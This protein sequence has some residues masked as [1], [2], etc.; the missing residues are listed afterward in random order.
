[1]LPT[2]VANELQDAVHRFLR[3]AFPIATPYFQ[4][5]ARASH[6]PQALIDDLLA[7]PGALFKGP[8][9]D[10]KLPFRLPEAEERFFRHL[11]LPFRP[12]LHQVNAF[13]R[14]SGDAP[15][16]TIIATGTGSGKTE[17]FM[18]PALDDC[19]N[20]REPGIKTIV[21]YPMNALATDQAERFAKEVNKLDT[22]LSVGLFVGGEQKDAQTRMSPEG[23]ITDQQTLREHPPDILLTNYK[24]LDFLLIRPRD[25]ALWQHNKPG[26]LRY[27]VVD[28]LHTF[29]GAQGTDLACLIRRLRDRLGAGPELACVGTSA[30]IGAESEDALLTYAGEVF[31]TGFDTAAVVREDRLS[32]DEYLLGQT[33]A[34]QQARR[35]GIEFFKWPDFDGAE[36]DPSDFER[37]GEYLVHQARLWFGDP[38]A[39]ELAG[40]DAPDGPERVRAAVR[41]GELLHRHQ[42]FHELVR[43]TE[44]L[45]DLSELAEHWR[46]R[47]NLKSADD[48]RRLLT[49]LASLVAAARLWRG[50][51]DNETDDTGRPFL[52]I[53]QQ[54]WLRELRRLV[55][56]VPHD[57][58]APVIRFADDLKDPQKP[59]HLPL[60][61]CRECHMAAWGA[62]KKDGDSHL[63]GDLQSFY[64]AWFKDSPQAMLLAPMAPGQEPGGRAR[65]FCPEC[66]RLQPDSNG[67]K[68]VECDGK[69][70]RR[71]WTPDMLK[72]TRKGGSE[73][74]QCHHDC[75]E[76]GARDSLA[77]IGYRAATL[78][79]VMTGRLFATPYN[80]D[81][82]LIAFSDSVQDAAHRAGFLGA[83]TWRQVVRQTMTGW[84]CDQAAP[85]SL[86]DVAASLPAFWRETIDDDAS[87][88]GL[89]I[90]PNMAWLHD[91]HALTD[92]GKL[93][94][95]SDLPDLIEK[96][97]AWECIAEFGRRGRIGR[98]L[99]R[100]GSAAVGLDA[101]QLKRDA[102]KL[103]ARLREEVEGLRVPDD[104]D[105]VAFVT[106]WLHHLRHIG[107]IYDP[108]LDSYLTHKGK[109]FL[110]NRLWWMPGF[111]R[112]RRPPAAVTLTHVAPNFEALV[113]NSRDTWSVRWLKK[114]LAREQVFVA[115][116]ARQI[117]YLCLQVLT[118]AGWLV[119]KHAGDEPLYLLNPDRLL[120]GG[121][122]LSAECGQC[123]HRVWFSPEVKDLYQGLHCLRSPC[124]G[125]LQPA[126]TARLS[127]DYGVTEPRRLVPSEHTGLLP[128][129]V[130]ESV[131]RSFIHGR[132]TW[133]INLLSATPT[134]EMGI[135]IGEL[136]SVFLCSVPPAQANYL[137]RIGR[138]GR[139]DGNALAVTVAN[140]RNHD[141]FF[142]SDPAE[143]IA[144]AVQT[145]GV[146]LQATA[147]LERQLIAYCF[148][149]WAATGIDE[150][151]IPGQLRKVLDAVKG[152][153]QDRFPYNLIAFVSS[154]HEALLSS[155]FGVFEH[156]DDEAREYLRRFVVDTGEGTLAWRLVNR[157]QQL[158]EEREV[159]LKKVRQLKQERD[160][161][162][163][164]PRDEATGELADLV[165]RERGALLSL[166]HSRNSQP[167][168]NFFT[169]EGL[170]PN[171]AF[172]EEGVTLQSVILRRRTREQVGAGEPSY[173]KVSYSFQ[174]PAQAALSELAPESRFYAV[175]HEM[176]IEQID[177][178]LS[179]SEEW[180]FCDRCQYTE[181][182]DIEDRHSACPRCG[183]AQWAD[184]GQKHTVLKLRQVYSTID[185]R[186]GRIGDDAEQRE[187]RFF[188][189]QMLVD[190]PPDGN[191]GGFRLASEALPFGFEFLRRVTLREVN[192][193]SMGGDSNTF[194][195]AGR[196]LSRRGFRI[197]R[198]CGKVQK[199]RW[200]RG[201]PHHAFTCTLRT[202]PR[203]ETAEDFFESLYLYRELHSEAI[204]ILLPLSEVAYSDEKLHSFVAALNLGLRNY[205]RGNVQHLE[206]TDMHE[207]AGS[208]SGERVYLVIYDRIP[209]GTGYL[210]ELMRTPE[211]MMRVLDAARQTLIH[212]DCNDNEERD[213]CYRCILAY[214]DSRN[215]TTISRKAAVELL[216]DILAL[217]DQ[218]EPVESLGDISTNVLIESKLEQRFVDALGRLSGARMMP[219]VINGK[220]GSMLT[221]PGGDGRPMP[222]QVEHQV[223]VGPDQGVAVQTEI[224][225]LLT[226]ARADDAERYRPIAVYLDG[227]QYHHDIVADDVIK[228]SA[229][230]MSGR[231]WVYSLNWHDI[232]EPGKLIEPQSFDVM[233][234]QG[235]AQ[236]ELI[237]IYDQVAASAEW[238]PSAEYRA[239]QARGSLEWLERQLREPAY[240]D[241][242]GRQFAV[243]R[244]FTALAPATAKD[245]VARDKISRELSKNAPEA[246][247]ESLAPGGSGQVPGGFMRSLENEI[248]SAGM[249]V[250]LPTSA[251]QSQSAG[252]L[253]EQLRVHLC[254]DDRD[255]QL[256]DEYKARWRAFW[257]AANR[258]QFLPG[259]TMAS[260]VAVESGKLDQ[261]WATWQALAAA[262]AGETDKESAAAS[263]WEDVFALSLLNRS[264]I[265][266]LME[267]ELPEPEVGVDLAGD[268]G[269]VTVSGDVVELCW[270][271]RKVAA[272]DPG[273]TASIA[274]WHLVSAD[275]EIVENMRQLINQGV[276]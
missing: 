161:L 193:G 149:R 273:A 269:E 30:T 41:L 65:R 210:K 53:R 36:R 49:S 163:Q 224:D 236:A 231:F 122:S 244:G 62:V 4:N 48:A 263:G 239:A 76:C 114:T 145:P 167:V 245:E 171:Y 218:L 201:E 77:I 183:S 137:Q 39:D 21:V 192:F 64:Q 66:L 259:F 34:E 235:R 194:S 40:L 242:E 150:S 232:P 250:S 199:E 57:A 134:L 212:C 142:Y 67:A 108:V 115:A 70:L 196:E 221:L 113:Q 16:S 91:Y 105:F 271:A 94:A 27:L 80:D 157:L 61:H 251:V 121:Q 187:P 52:E 227:L 124:P 186:A 79:S 128:R 197:C 75:P 178:Q 116:E 152:Q 173:D 85:R 45:T 43:A 132:E 38:Y 140:G 256:T 95:G 32:P 223:R 35:E 160:R 203:E 148:D 18:L 159:L 249:T 81:Y 19:L 93:P 92:K 170:L 20:R 228:R 69:T 240:A 151:A 135:D 54:L 191:R 238:L 246:I 83:N 214:R 258:L 88:C 44:A 11:K 241:G 257:Y 126:T 68:C 90:A 109:E 254:F 190:T 87:Y 153:R 24:M 28:E 264:V 50:A 272:V 184:N 181:R 23:V 55:C 248:L 8:Y 165:E 208:G 58:Q 164:Q 86:A 237:G 136:S 166:L 189:R 182:V 102:G 104:A 130:R 15:Q 47:L 143:M 216:N 37:A 267:L 99:E 268:D 103:A 2:V 63:N 225:V 174:R 25:Q 175:S 129:D 162:K 110:L 185:D 260:R 200:R 22:Q 60:L 172:P 118:Q 31:A 215:M 195:V 13:R 261:L 204:R 73:R 234:A 42:A 112:S 188:N 270:P 82:K 131:E 119:E 59:L 5:S 207:P 98:S 7:R 100:T 158:V 96:R 101:A 276:F 147:V 169:D 180:R 177:L 84:L 120:I 123:R 33:Q 111:G 29:D 138:A 179:N 253:A 198:H 206:V 230:L 97:L 154:N 46:Q 226:P 10:I 247:R 202:H 71:V 176:P 3:S 168:L 9:L 233:E 146:F 117:F 51:E 74:L 144:G 217:R 14:L 72:R 127:Q 26:M 229:L 220:A 275:D 274:G 211:N 266:A 56:S 209:G 12:F 107:S 255:T 17:C 78:T 156:L 125:L 1:M 213:G 265:Q 106:G 155:F 262:K 6:D 243:Y 222:W 133:D 139:R 205:F 252:E 89:F 219:S 141:L